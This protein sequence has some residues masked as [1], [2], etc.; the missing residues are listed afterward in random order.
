MNQKS[1][2][3]NSNSPQPPQP[4]QRKKGRI[5]IRP[6]ESTFPSLSRLHNE[7]PLIFLD[8]PAGTQVPTSVIESISNYYKTSNSNAHGH[9][10]LTQETDQIIESTRAKVATFLGAEGGHTISFGQNMTSL[11]FALSRAIAPTLNPGDEIVIT[12][13]D[14]E[15]NRAPWLH[16]RSQGV[17]VR[18]VKLKA[19]GLLDYKDFAEKINENTRLVAMGWASNIFGTINDVIK[20]RKLS[21]QVGALLLLDAVHYAPHLSIDVQAIGCDFLLCSA[22]KFYGPHVGLLYCKPGLLDRLQPY[23]LRT[24]YQH[25]PYSIET[26]T[27]NH[28]AIAGV[29]ASIEFIET[30]GNGANERLRLVN[31]L[32]N[33]HQHEINLARQLYDGLSSI[34]KVKIYGPPMDSIQ[35]APT[36]S[37]LYKGESSTSIGK[38]LAKHNIC[39]W[40]GHFYAIKATEVLG[41]AEK[42]GV[43][44]MGISLY[45]TEEDIAQTIEVMRQL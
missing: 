23:R 11:N 27:L 1:V 39:T 12:Q 3:A 9:F 31:A 10:I 30:F 15:S 28:A 34:K 43:T 17:K 26:G 22:Y 37:F 14:H 33:I 29:K 25:A 21:H 8:G 36:L 7:Q 2:R 6:N 38:Y 4:P 32:Q 44:R 42:G 45:N 35:R 16:L 20:I 24:A 18:E 40:S 19:D 13:L 5:A 41:L